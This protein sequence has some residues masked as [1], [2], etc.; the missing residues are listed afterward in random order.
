MTSQFLRR[1]VVAPLA[2]FSLAVP[3]LGFGAFNE[4]LAESP[5]APD[6]ATASS[7]DAPAPTEATS[8]PAA[9][10]AAPAGEELAPT[11]ACSDLVT[12]PDILAS[13]TRPDGS[14]ITFTPSPSGKITPVI[15]VH[16]FVSWVNHDEGR[17]GYFSHYID[18]TADGGAGRVLAKKDVHTSLVGLIQQI[19]GAAPYMFDYS[20]IASRWVTDPGIGP[21][22]GK[23]I[24]CLSRHYGVK[25]VIIAHS[26]GGNATREA[27]A[28]DDGAGGTVADHVSRVITFG[29]PNLGSDN[30]ALIGKVLEGAGKPLILGAPA[31][32]LKHVWER[33]GE[34]M[35]A[36]GKPCIGNPVVDAF[37][38]SGGKALWTGSPEMAALPPWPSKVHVT[39]L[40]GDIQIGGITM[41][42]W[43]SA[44]LLDVGDMLVSEPSAV[45]GA[46]DTNV[47]RC[48]YGI[49]STASALNGIKIVTGAISGGERPATALE[50]PCWHEALLRETTQTGIAHDAVAALA[51]DPQ[52]DEPAAQ[53]AP[54]QRR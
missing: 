51:A 20:A 4:A 23:A 32:L 2:A 21:R 13:D 7:V 6:E 54:A 25:P 19:P 33:C 53:P 3:L 44:R 27:L 42:G 28:Q 38:S 31:R 35:D 47:V 45:A 36:S 37:L 16:G 1:I 26:M 49:V 48:E 39:A 29:T 43:K 24:T 50:T 17:T 5:T 46:T 8:E 10:E 52:L 41:F 30:A 11:G 40:A 18:K 15:F 9:D 12:T 34:G 22:L 14:P